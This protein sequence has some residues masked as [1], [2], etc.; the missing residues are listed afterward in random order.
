MKTRHGMPALLVVAHLCAAG[1]PAWPQEAGDPE[2]DYVARFLE[3]FPKTASAPAL[4]AYATAARYDALFMGEN[5]KE[6]FASPNNDQGGLAWGLAY[7]MMSLNEMYR[8][9]GDAKYLEAHLEGIRAVL[10]ATDDKRGKEL[11]TGAVARAWGCDKYAKRG[12]AVFAVHTGVIAHPILECLLLVKQDPELSSALGGEHDAILK[13]TEE[14]LAYHDRQWRDGPGDGEGH[15]IGLDQEEVCENKPLPGNR[16]SAM[17]RALWTAWKLTGNAT[18][19]D[20]ALAIGRYIK[21]RFTLAPDGAY[22]W[23]Y[24]LPLEAVV[25][26]AA[27][28]PASGEDTSHGGL[29]AS[30]PMMLGVEGEVFDGEDMK[31]LAGT[32]LK[33][34]GRRTDGVLFG[35]VTG[36]PGSKPGYVSLPARWL[37]LAGTAPEVRDRIVPFY[38]N[39]RPTPSPLDLALLLRYGGK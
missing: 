18:H 37:M 27:D 17:G 16:L 33:G 29:T 28:R 10:A 20:R 39:H 21:N 22:Y 12:R 2:A 35:D 8:A 31:R 34:F 4:D 24:W 3:Q 26:P 11:W 6:A 36:N 23:P 5:V 1:A 25:N 19:R 7:R 32:V 14:A 38:L 30:F 9:T 13:A 15:Y